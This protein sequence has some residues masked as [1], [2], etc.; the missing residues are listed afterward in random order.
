M[1]SLNLLIFS[2]LISILSLLVVLVEIWSELMVLVNQKQSTS[3]TR[4]TFWFTSKINLCPVLP[5]LSTCTPNL[6]ISRAEWRLMSLMSV[7]CPNSFPKWLC[8]ECIT[9]QTNQNLSALITLKPVCV[10][11]LTVCCLHS[12][13]SCLVEL[14]IDYLIP[15]IFV[16]L[17]SL[18]TRW[19]QND[20]CWCSD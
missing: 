1:E 16:P 11:Q 8:F 19:T 17:N 9:C 7:L 15:L 10:G 2:T 5:K 12:R 18:S 3:A 20:K 6:S 14:W 13:L 4:D